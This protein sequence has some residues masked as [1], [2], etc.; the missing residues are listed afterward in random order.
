MKFC[1]QEVSLHEVV[2]SS[3]LTYIATVTCGTMALWPFM[4][5]PQE[6]GS[7]QGKSGKVKNIK[8]C[9]GKRLRQSAAESILE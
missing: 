9:I 8:T 5:S 2:T 1:R 4:Q 3:A 6:L 7:W